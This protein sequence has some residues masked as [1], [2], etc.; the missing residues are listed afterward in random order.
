MS[1][2][3]KSG[4]L[5]AENSNRFVV[6]DIATTNRTTAEKLYQST[7]QNIFSDLN[8]VVTTTA[9]QMPIPQIYSSQTQEDQTLCESQ[10]LQAVDPYPAWN[11][12]EQGNVVA[13]PS[14]ENKEVPVG[15]KNSNFTDF[16][17]KVSDIAI[18]DSV[19]AGNLN[20][21]STRC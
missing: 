4:S 17:K 2:Y 19:V 3:V 5:L 21:Q 18:S 16:F 6:L 14:E 7:L 9:V 1:Y 10:Q 8:V 15:E 12:D 11:M 13:L 20:R